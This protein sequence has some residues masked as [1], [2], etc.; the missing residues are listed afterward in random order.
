MDKNVLICP[1][2]WGLGHF[3]RSVPIAEKLVSSGYT[4]YFAVN[5]K[6]KN[7]LHHH[8]PNALLI[9]FPSYKI[10]YSINKYLWLK[11]FLQAPKIIA[12][13]ITEY[14]ATQKTI[15]KYS[16]SVIISDNRYGC[17]SK[18]T[19]NIFI[20]HQVT[21]IMP[22]QLK[23][24]Q[25]VSDYVFRKLI[26]RFDQCWIPDDATIH[27]TG[28]LTGNLDKIRKTSFIGILS[29][30]NCIEPQPLQGIS[31]LD[32][33]AVISGPEPQR[34]ILEEIIKT[35]FQKSGKQCM[36]VR[37]KPDLTE[38]IDKNGNVWVASH[39]SSGNLKYVLLL[40][41]FILCRAGYSSIMDLIS[42]ERTAVLVPTP[43]QTEQEYLATKL[44]E[45]KMFIT[46]H[47][48]N[49]DLE[50]AEKNLAATK[51]IEIQNVNFLEL[52]PSKSEQKKHNNH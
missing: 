32:W 37:G 45:K 21:P 33:L 28:K 50:N 27:V 34:S 22:A 16:V 15:N 9:N 11:L 19:H 48:H 39:L 25:T 20:T 3:T 41:R 38:R 40:S 35:E 36:V 26:N 43:G 7:L 51:K 1:L 30:F 8:L 49:L 23:S 18:K 10:T 47:Q 2:T 14:R 42:L 6:F 24:F 13:F 17:F 46:Q 31:K 52:L 4:V 5:H 29:R 44:A 12:G